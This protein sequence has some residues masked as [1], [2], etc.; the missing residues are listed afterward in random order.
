MEDTS[1]DEHESG[2]KLH[3]YS[4]ADEVDDAQRCAADEYGRS[5]ALLRPPGKYQKCA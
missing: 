1:I 2:V 4:I 3:Y 5:L